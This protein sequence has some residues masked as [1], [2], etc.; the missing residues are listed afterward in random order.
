MTDVGERGR[1]TDGRSGGTGGL[2]SKA[3]IGTRLGD[4]KGSDGSDGSEL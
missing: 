4:W 1:A 3:G 2:C